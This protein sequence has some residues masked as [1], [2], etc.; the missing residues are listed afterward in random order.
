MFYQKLLRNFLIILALAP[1]AAQASPVITTNQA[2]QIK[3]VSARLNG[4]L[5]ANSV[6]LW[7]WYFK[8]GTTS[9]FEMGQLTDPLNFTVDGAA[10]GAKPDA[11]SLTTSVLLPNTTYYYQL[12]AR[13]AQDLN[14]T[15]QGETLTFTTG[16]PASRPFMS[17]PPSGAILETGYN[18][19]VA[20]MSIQA[21]SSPAKVFIY[22]GLTDAYGLR[23][24]L[25]D[26][27]PSN[28]ETIAKI[29][30]SNLQ[31]AS[32]YHYR[33]IAS[34][35]EGTVTSE[36]RTFSTPTAP[37]VQTLAA[38]DVNYFSAILHGRAN[39]RDGSTMTPHFDVGTTTSY[40]S[41]YIPDNLN[42][43]P[44]NT[45]SSLNL[46]IGNLAPSTTY[47]FRL[48]GTQP[49]TDND[50]AGE[51]LTFTTGP[52]GILPSIE[53]EI[54][55]EQITGYSALVRLDRVSAGNGQAT[56]IVEYGPSDEYGLETYVPGIFASQSSDNIVSTGLENLVPATTYHFRFRITNPSGFIYSLPGVFTTPAPPEVTTLPA[57]NIQ[58]D[59]ATLCGSVVTNGNTCDVRI[60]WG[61]STDYGNFSRVVFDPATPVQ[62][63]LFYFP[64]AS[65][66]HYRLNV[67]DGKNTYLG[68]DL[69]F[70]TLP[71]I[72][73]PPVIYSIRKEVAH[74]SL[75]PYPFIPRS[76][77]SWDTARVVVNSFGGTS[78]S[79]L[80]VEY[81]TSAAYG[82]VA[83][84]AG[85]WQSNFDTSIL[86]DDLL[87]AT[88]YHCRAKISST[89]GTDYSADL[90]FTTMA[91]PVLLS[92]PVVNIT[93]HGAVL[94][95]SLDPKRWYFFPEIEYG[96]TPACDNTA[97][98]INLTAVDGWL[99][100]VPGRIIG[101]VV[102]LTA[103]TE[104]LLPS[105]TYYYRL[106]CTTPGTDGSRVLT[107]ALGTFTTSPPSTPPR[108]LGSLVASEIAYDSATLT[109]AN[110]EAGSSAASAVFAFG[111][112]TA[113]GKQVSYSGQMPA[114][115]AGNPSVTLD[116]L[117]PATLYHARVTIQNGQGQ[118]QS[119]DITFTTAPL[120]AKPTINST[121]TANVIGTSGV[122]LSASVSAGGAA[123][124][125][126]YEYGP[127]NTYGSRLQVATPITTGNTR[128]P[129]GWLENLTPGTTYHAR[130]TA[131]N[132]YG[133]VSTPDIVFTTF[134]MP[135]ITT[136]PPS[137]V[138]D[139]SA[140][141]NASVNANGASYNPTF[142]WGLSTSYG[143]SLAAVPYSISGSDL[144]ALSA[145]LPGLLSSTTYHYR[146][147]AGTFLGTDIAFTTAAATTLPVITGNI[148]PFAIM[149]DSIS[150]KVATSI[151]A[152]GSDATVIF[153]YGPTT[154]YGFETAAAGTIL[155]GTTAISPSVALTG[156]TSDTIYHG[157][158]K[159]TNG[160][161]TTYS[162]DTEFSTAFELLTQPA[163]E[164]TDI[165]ARI[166]GSVNAGGGI[167][168][169]IYFQW[170]TTSSYSNGIS[171]TPATATGT[172]T[173]LV[174]A[175]L[176]GLLPDTLYYYRLTG[177]D[178]NNTLYTGPQLTFQ[179]S[180]ATSPPSSPNPIIASALGL[181]TATVQAPNVKS[182][183]SAATVTFE[184]GTTL[185]YGSE[186]AYS[187]SL[188][189]NTSSSPQVKLTGLVPATTYHVR[190]RIQNVQGTA[191]SPDTI[192][193]T[194]AVPVL[195]TDNATNVT[196]L[197]AMMNGQMLYPG[198]TLY[199][200]RFVYGSGGSSNSE[201]SIT[202]IPGAVSGSYILSANLTSLTPNTTYQYHI[203][204]SSPWG[205]TYVSAAKSFTTGPANTPP[206]MSG[207]L[208]VAEIS[209]N[210]ARLQP[211]IIFAGSST[212]A[213]VFEY[214]LT[215]SYEET[216]TSNSI[217]MNQRSGESADLVNLHPSTTYQ[218]R[219]KATNAQG[220]AVSTNIT[221]TTTATPTVTTL[222]PTSVTDITAIFNGSVNPKAG[223]LNVSYEWGENSTT[224]NT[225]SGTLFQNVTGTSI[226]T[227]PSR[228]FTDL[229]PSTTYYYR[230]IAADALNTWKG[231]LL[232]F[233]TPGPSSPPSLNGNLTVGSVTTKTASAT[234]KN[235]LNADAILGGGS[236]ATTSLQYGTTTAYGS[237]VT[238]MN[239]GSSVSAGQSLGAASGTMT[240]LSGGTLYN[241]RLKVSS[242]IGTVYSENITFTTLTDPVL[243]TGGVTAP[244]E[245]SAPLSADATAGP[246]TVPLI[247]YF[248]WG[249]TMSYGSSSFA[250]YGY[251]G[252]TVPAGTTAQ[253]TLPIIG[254]SPG[255]P[256]HYRVKACYSVNSPEPIVWYYG[257]DQTFS[258]PV[259]STPPQITTV[260]KV[261]NIKSTTAIVQT[262]YF[263]GSTAT[264]VTLEYGPTTSYGSQAAL[265]TNLTPNAAANGNATLTNLLPS[266]IYHVRAKAVNAQGTAYGEDATFT[267]ATPPVLALTPV[268]GITSSSATLNGS[269][270]S[271]DATVPTFRFE[272]GLT[273]S[274]G[275]SVNA[276]RNGTN[277]S[278]IINGLIPSTTYH[279]RLVATDGPTVRV[280]EDASFISGPPPAAPVL[281][282]LSAYSI[283]PTAATLWIASVSAP[284]T[285]LFDYGLTTSYGS[286][287]VCPQS[288]SP[289]GVL[290]NPTVEL[291][292]LLPD[293]IYHYRCRAINSLGTTL[294]NDST[295]RTLA[296]PGLSTL[297]PEGLEDKSLKLSGEINA[298]N[299][300]LAPSFE[301]GTTT[302][303]GQVVSIQAAIVS[304]ATPTPVSVDVNDLLPE[305]TY[306]FR[307]K[308]R[309]PRG[310]EY[311]GQTMAI[312]TLSLA[313]AWRLR[314][315]GITESIDDAADHANPSGDGIP[316]L[317]KYALDLDPK[318]STALPNMGLIRTTATGQKM[319]FSFLRDPQKPDIT[320]CVEAANSPTG[321]WQTLAT[322]SSGAQTSGI[323]YL[324]ESDAAD[325]KR[326]VDVQ[327]TVEMSVA[328]TRFMR[329]RVE[330]D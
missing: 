169:N 224:L 186:L 95:A 100:G 273:T 137:Q 61:T 99:D 77:I 27:V 119:Q 122:V 250:S 20:R 71:L 243:V 193:T 44:G 179:T 28:S 34:N 21:G 321:P 200:V 131:T 196:D 112:T 325:G 208:T 220:I 191:Y 326:K 173:L 6:G 22:Y 307:L 57:K 194:P 40:G 185:A 145:S 113:Y 302:D 311:F 54:R 174:S 1:L 74:F 150:L 192:F 60:E 14:N 98:Q 62:E 84:T 58:D 301:M 126:V 130:C 43:L 16:P 295:F 222:P 80:L 31:A 24:A 7:T 288:T 138:M 290:R 286:V 304:G 103:V 187:Y 115:W 170:G 37:L 280:T 152:G 275:S 29:R 142:E 140:V 59:H 204:A 167:L 164:V 212:T 101:D 157:R 255:K 195:T 289:G 263:T 266:S 276:T 11:L 233:T 23:T 217:S 19:A 86:L 79:T 299:G 94:A 9:A 166:N 238:V 124:T 69:S 277:L 50:T 176:P 49:N 306:H 82:K 252:I 2:T 149:P 254:L 190:C 88:T 197:S 89:L 183:A 230:I 203:E 39:P 314:Y 93:D 292:N 106:K 237:S 32:T 76:L 319:G 228:L 48:R 163:T 328:H 241:V 317:I 108:I 330:R 240:G 46:R 271:G 139:L 78:P 143:K 146:I 225:L 109:I 133:S 308:A 151:K 312:K 41:V 155:A 114:F 97:L 4:T 258:T 153:E 221:F 55:V 296:L 249:L 234:F 75:P 96:L 278:S 261:S 257:T 125:I 87:P 159:V 3:D 272:W 63:W 18:V 8:I 247:V 165:T 168:S 65:T 160:Q 205:E 10:S 141:L 52:A 128:F 180:S 66:I 279:Y 42:F 116:G 232:N 315:F 177:Y 316:N 171:A 144:N 132:I 322:S 35:A 90:V 181:Y 26:P 158:F 30:L 15:I 189:I 111:L 300:L 117:T 303:F 92:Q 246:G 135:V 136:L 162:A 201:Y 213:V 83:T 47:H 324:G 51:D 45:T 259:A 110:V 85:A 198:L 123:A 25:E 309:D 305:T 242:S 5:N 260:P 218:A 13:E 38:T 244:G 72:P 206:S 120:G 226:Q 210:K 284:A 129:Q 33:W 148:I 227:F 291:A 265:A 67:F 256:Y 239:I 223:T 102:P 73:K 320:Y 281:G 105:T 327:D 147:K 274:Y 268:S 68:Q 53:S 161:G 219:C 285:V 264:T 12:G 235:P 91:A 134:Q 251:S 214:G 184:Y 245:F 211:P 236:N 172:E 118:K 156:L 36:D 202:S 298:R 182:G 121:V 310:A 175:I 104:A 269:V 283:T 178:G 56:A 70:T 107:S 229:K 329:L 293:A 231:T 215:T 282:V 253:L 323:G 209:N 262:G 267:T 64:T 294:A 17:N 199:S 154:S 318:K 127:T 207:V 313:Q 81:G 297:Q 188:P 270:V 248:D 287:A 216:K